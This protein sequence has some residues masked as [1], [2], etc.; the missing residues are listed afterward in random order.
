[1]ELKKLTKIIL[2]MNVFSILVFK[3]PILFTE[4]IQ[5]YFIF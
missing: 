1:M 4:G 5:K 2:R 3:T